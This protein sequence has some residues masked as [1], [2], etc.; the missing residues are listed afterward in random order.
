RRNAI[1]GKIRRELRC[2][3]VRVVIGADR[4]EQATTERV[5]DRVDVLAVAE[6][7]LPHPERRVRALESLA[8]EIEVERPRLAVH[9]ES[10]RLR[11]R[12][13][14]ESDARGQMHEV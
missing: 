11:L 6:R 12:E 4:V 7:R 14:R 9:A 1:E 3:L 8:R 10:L 5:P 2:A 13:R